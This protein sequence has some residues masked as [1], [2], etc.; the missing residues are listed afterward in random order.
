M[1]A[2]GLAF[3]CALSLVAAC[4]AREAPLPSADGG[5]PTAQDGGTG[6]RPIVTLVDPDFGPVE[7]GTP[8]TIYGEHFDP[9]ALVSVGGIFA[10]DV[11]VLSANRITARTPPALEAGIVPVR[12]VNPGGEFGEL[13][14]GFE[15]QA[16]PPL[17]IGWCRLEG[18]ARI[19]A[20]PNQVL[21]ARGRVY[22]AERTPG[23][24]RGEGV[25]AQVGYG[26]GALPPANW[27]WIP[28]AYDR[29]VDG[30]AAG[31]LANDE[32]LGEL[33]VPLAGD[34]RLAF[35][36][37]G[38]NGRTWTVCDLDGTDNGF[39]V[40]A[41]AE[42]AV[43]PRSVGF[44]NLQHPASTSAA[45]GETTEPFY[46][47]VFVDGVTPGVGPGPGVRA[48]LG[49]GPPG[50]SPASEAWRWVAA[51]YNVDVDGLAS[52]DLA[53]DEYTAALTVAEA[54]SYDVA[55]RFSADE[56]ATWTYCD[57]DGTENGYS[58]A[59][60][61]ALI[62]EPAGGGVDWCRFE[63]PSPVDVLL[64][65]ATPVLRGRV[66]HA[67]VTPGAG[68]GGGIQGQV[69]FGPPTAAVNGVAW[70]WT[71]AAYLG[72]LDGPSPGDLADDEH[73]AT[74]TPSL[75]G[76]YAVA[77]RF[78][79]GEGAWSYC[80][81]DGL[82]NGFSLD[83]AGI[84][85]MGPRAVGYCEINR[86][87]APAPIVQGQEAP[88]FYG[89]VY[90]AGRTPGAGQGADVRGQVGYGTV[91]DPG[92]WDWVEATYAG[93]VDG[94]AAG[95]KANDEY[96]AGFNPAAPGTYH[97]AY[98]FSVDGGQSW[99]LCDRDGGDFSL[100]NAATL[101]VAAPTVGYCEITVGASAV[102][103]RRGEATGPI[104]GR[105]YVATRTPGNG[106]G[107]GIT[108]Q[109]GYGPVG[110]APATWPAASWAGAS[111]FSDVDGL[112]SGDLANDEYRSTLIVNTEGTYS[113]GY[114][115]SVDGGASWTYCDRDG[116]D[117]D[118]PGTL[119]VEPPPPV[120]SAC[121]LEPPLQ[122]VVLQGMRTPSIA[123]RVYV[124]GVTDANGQGGGV[125]AEVGYGPP[126]SDSATWTIW[127]S[128]AYFGDAEIDGLSSDEYRG[129]LVAPSQGEYDFAIR[130][131]LDGAQSWTVC[132]DASGLPGV[133]SSRGWCNLQSP[134]S[135]TTTAGSATELLFGR[136]FVDG[137]TNA[138]G[139][140]AGVVAELGYGPNPSDPKL[141]PS[142]WTWSSAAY[143]ALCPDCDGEGTDEYMGTLTVG[144]P[145]SYLYTFRYSIDGGQA[146]CYGTLLVGGPYGILTV[147]Q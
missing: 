21:Q 122:I 130:F 102:R 140:G 44:C 2:P 93:D 20:V 103:V 115:F 76:T 10:D 11:I 126:G 100:G 60:A 99:T 124:P 145:G 110:A 3:A 4:S 51:S 82:D 33:A 108:G 107:P 22:V 32:Y 47:R 131:S 79:V 56:G 128:A 9:R 55:F 53:N 23:A 24:G 57:R 16:P 116:G 85:R 34:Y 144:T 48:E 6:D 121:R 96:S 50:E 91:A 62:V 139:Q 73:G 137:V 104:A 84:L 35:R 42:L 1:R 138:S 132:E 75:P 61:G 135:T 31:D 129:T 120:L 49:Y 106:P 105:V 92:A 19:V 52:G 37:S 41:T 146:W 112:V 83:Q 123:G 90:V 147:N 7:G 30:L 39:E 114:R 80:D 88:A 86:P 81:L 25:R 46:G 70:T 127:S 97:I 134:S 58:S 64:G 109:L 43:H 141:D 113:I 71:N 89:R 101:M 95:D 78:R 15:Y 142:G 74:L 125:L 29:D 87:L 17:A 26:F 63:G 14:D 117:F 72:D 67:G 59:Q 118:Q 40:A 13:L 98:R 5:A 136:V 54:G 65:Q 8:I 28:A 77:F 119:I 133:L 36:F 18:A 66:Y 27:T 111:Y 143:N 94:L 12:V 38:D 69:G 68:Q 45:P